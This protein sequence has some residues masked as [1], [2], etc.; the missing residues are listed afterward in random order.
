MTCQ[1]RIAAGAEVVDAVLSEL[2]LHLSELVTR[3][4]ARTD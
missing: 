3:P 4:F 1:L 2:C